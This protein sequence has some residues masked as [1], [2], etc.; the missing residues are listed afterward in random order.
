MAMATTGIA[1]ERT[2]Q[3]STKVGR[4]MKIIILMFLFV[5]LTGCV[6]SGV[7]E[8]GPNTYTITVQRPPMAGGVA[9][10]KGEAMKEAKDYCANQFQKVLVQRYVDQPGYPSTSSITF[11][12][13]NPDD[14]ELQRPHYRSDPN[15]IIETRP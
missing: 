15:V 10:A 1:Y 8:M 4:Y 11:M 13:L 5:I 7:L 2:F 14:P 6:S 9:A 3:S 12:C